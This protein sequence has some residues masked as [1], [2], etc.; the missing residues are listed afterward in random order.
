MR[1]RG[2]L[3]RLAV[4]CITIVLV[5][6]NSV[7]PAKAGA[8]TIVVDNSSFVDEVN[9]SVWS[10]PDGN[11]TVENSML[12][13]PKNSTSATRLIT[14]TAARA[15]EMNEELLN[16]TA[17]IR[18]ETLPSG[19]KFILALGL[20]SIEAMAGASG[21][22]EIQFANNGGVK[23]SVVAFGTEGEQQVI[24]AVSLGQLNQDINVQVSVTKDGQLRF[25]TGNRVLG[26]VK[27]PVSGEGRVGFLQ[28]GN[29]AAKVKD[30]K[31]VSYRYDTPEN[32]DIS[33][34]FESK[35]MNVNLLTSMM[36]MRPSIYRPCYAAI[37]EYEGN[38]VFM[39]N[40]SGET[41]IGTLYKYS[42][43]EMSFDVPYLQTLA[44]WN[45]NG[46]AIKPI[47][48][49]FLVGWGYSS[50]NPTGAAEYMTA[51]QSVSF[52]SGSQVVPRGYEDKT[53]VSEKYPFF[54]PGEERGVSIKVSV[55]DTE[56][57]VYMKWIEETIWT[58]VLRYHTG[59][60][61]SLGY[62][63]LW[64]LTPGNIAIDNL[65]IVNK[66][67]NPKLLT[68]DAKY[69]NL[70]KVEDYQYKKAEYI[71]KDLA[72][73]EETFNWYSLIPIVAGVCVVAFGT[74]WGITAIMRRKKGGSHDEE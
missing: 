62:I 18:L 21:N 13:F 57:V 41:Y 51:E 27:L 7:I 36:T 63:Q 33:E 32:S 29:C 30:L 55:V 8:S 49:E 4:L 3:S 61:T 39:C 9:N 52:R 6:G 10:N 15:S 43:F 45:K 16:V 64:V 68:V 53:V 67:A 47:C 44:E 24:S 35:S 56:V 2:L 31:V 72:V 74:T 1:R 25:M 34:D 28:T 66:D 40:N 65:K 70:D 54:T 14:K 42:N 5:A 38:Q 12:V 17:T 73:K 26:K 59:T 37:Q 50:P 19:E 22:V 60:L 71:Y 58:E 46:E 23:A 69:D 20:S 11:V 48:G